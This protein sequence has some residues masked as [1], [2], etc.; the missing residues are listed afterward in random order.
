MLKI[1]FY[2]N[3]EAR[4]VGSHSDATGANFNNGAVVN[5]LAAETVTG[6]IRRQ[7]QDGEIEAQVVTLRKAGAYGP[8]GQS[9]AD[10]LYTIPKIDRVNDV[11]GMID[12]LYG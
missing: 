6:V 11:F 7:S 12:Y 3:D 4:I 1:T 9:Q 2:P 10:R 5:H 8:L